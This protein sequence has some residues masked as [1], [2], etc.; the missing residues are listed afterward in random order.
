MARKQDEEVLDLAG[1]VEW[2]FRNITKPD[3]SEY[4]LQ[5]AE[6]ETARLG[7]RI[8]STGIWKIRHGETKNPGYLAL[9]S[10]ARFFKVP[11][12]V[13]YDDD[14]GEAE[15]R[16]YRLALSIESPEVEQIAFRASHFNK[17]L[18]RT[19]LDMLKNIPI[20]RSPDVGPVDPLDPP[21]HQGW[22]AEDS[23]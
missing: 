19:I 4:T 18:Q 3:G 14:I 11:I 8:T 16:R 22:D 21:D 23:E 20:T 13:F 2:L 17:R 9:R 15:L 10:L 6:E 5:E 1:R 12:T 7:H